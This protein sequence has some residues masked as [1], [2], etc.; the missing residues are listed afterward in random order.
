MIFKNFSPAKELE[1]LVKS[2]HVRHF[3]FPANA[4]IPPKP[5]TPRD[6]QYLAFYVKGYETIFLQRDQQKLVRKKTCIIGQSTQL[7]QRVVS[8]QFLIIQVP[9]YPGALFK[10]TG[11]PFYE[12]RDK[13]LDLELVYP[14]ETREIDE[15]L[16][17]AKTYSE[18]IELINGFLIQL[19]KKSSYHY[20]NAFDRALPYLFQSEEIKNVDFLANQAC[21]SIRQFERLSKDYF[22][23][24]PKM[25]IRINRFTRSYIFKSRNPNLSWVDVAFA[26]GFED[27]QHMAKEYK[28]FA[29]F[30]P[31]QLWEAEGKAPD[32]ILGLR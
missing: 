31:P 26:C 32:R 10:L 27:Y 13:C 22:G 19:F 16:A 8:S 15:R 12:L 28:I 29:G 18:M 4:T 25:M 2:Y 20:L 7:V 3:E 17:E 6:E 24:S 23:V 14:Q 30:T 1:G 21:L 9:F 11:I 5:F